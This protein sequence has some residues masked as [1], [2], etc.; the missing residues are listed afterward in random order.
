MTPCYRADYLT[1]LGLEVANA[2][3]SKEGKRKGV[4]FWGL[5]RR[6]IV[7]GKDEND[8]DAALI[9]EF[10]EDMRGA[11]VVAW[12]RTGP[13]TRKRIDALRPV[14]L[15][16][17]RE[18]AAIHTEQWDA[19]RDRTFDGHDA[20]GAILRAAES[21]PAGHV[22]AAVDVLMTQLLWEGR[23]GARPPPAA[24]GRLS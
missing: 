9:R 19:V 16:A 20:R 23:A 1:K 13:C 10:I 14:T 21:A 6:W 3:Q 24:A 11:V 2:A 7:N 12:P 5:V 8:R 15:P 17:V 22:Q 4:A 18:S